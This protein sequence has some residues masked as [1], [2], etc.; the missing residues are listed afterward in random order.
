VLF[1]CLYL[2]LPTHPNLSRLGSSQRTKTS[3]LLEEVWAISDSL[4]PSCLEISSP[5][6]RE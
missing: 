2:S 3:C 6:S 1:L 4:P 5:T